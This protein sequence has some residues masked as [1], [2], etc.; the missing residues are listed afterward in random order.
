MVQD[1]NARIGKRLAPARAVLPFGAAGGTGGHSALSRYLAG[2]SVSPWT[3][4]VAICE[5][6]RVDPAEL[7]PDWLMARGGRRGG[8]AK[9][10]PA[11]IHAELARDLTT[12][13]EALD[14]AIRSVRDLGSPVCEHLLAAR[15]AA[16][17]AAHR[18]GSAQ[19]ADGRIGASADGG[20][21][22]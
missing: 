10:V 14:A 4:V 1:G 9:R 22:S 6:G 16:V 18:L 21:S 7:R 13:T 17:D 11:R 3:V 20:T 19:G 15:H 12:I 2:Q 5:L 8:A